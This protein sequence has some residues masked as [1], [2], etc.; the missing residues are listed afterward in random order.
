METIFAEREKKLY[1][2]LAQTLR[3]KAAAEGITAADIPASDEC[4]FHDSSYYSY[5]RGDS[6]RQDLAF[7][8]MR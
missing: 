7:L 2:D 6:G 3:I 8:M 1:L 5:R 4:T